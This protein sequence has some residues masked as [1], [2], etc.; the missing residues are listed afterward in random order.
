MKLQLNITRL[1]GAMEITL[2]TDGV[3]AESRKGVMEWKAQRLERLEMALEA[4]R[5]SPDAAEDIANA[6]LEYETDGEDAE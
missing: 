1:A 2:T 3:R 4:V 6:A 5:H